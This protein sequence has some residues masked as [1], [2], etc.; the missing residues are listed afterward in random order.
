MR[1][2]SLPKAVTWKWTGQDSNPRRP[3]GSRANAL[4]YAT[5]VTCCVYVYCNSGEEEEEEEEEEDEDED[6]DEEE[7]EEEEEEE[8]EDEQSP[9]VQVKN[10]LRL[11]WYYHHHHLFVQSTSNSHVQ[12]CNIVEQDSKVQERTLTAARKRRMI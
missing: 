6:E 12:Q 5:Q 3:F 1:L 4:L 7:G 9:S 11:Q 10:I 8:E 2:S